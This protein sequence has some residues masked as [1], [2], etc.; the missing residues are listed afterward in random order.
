VGPRLGFTLAALELLLKVCRTNCIVQHAVWLILSPCCILVQAWLVGVGVD[1][2]GLMEGQLT[3]PRAWQLFEEDGT[4]TQVRLMGHIYTVTRLH[5]SIPD[6]G[7]F[8]G[9]F[10]LVAAGNWFGSQHMGLHSPREA[11]HV[12]TV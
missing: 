12:C 5:G 1:V 4:R 6:A 9:P 7:R 8:R 3:T 10:F 11:P 2:S